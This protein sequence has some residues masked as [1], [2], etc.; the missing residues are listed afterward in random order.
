MRIVAAALA[1]LAVPPVTA[2][3]NLTVEGWTFTGLALLLLVAGTVL[4]F[5]RRVHMRD[6]QESTGAS[7]TLTLS[8][9]FLYTASLLVPWSGSYMPGAFLWG[10][11]VR[12]GPG[13]PDTLFLFADQARTNS[14]YLLWLALPL[15][16]A[17]A[18]LTVVGGFRLLGK[19]PQGA[20]HWG[21]L[22]LLLGGSAMIL[23]IL[24]FDLSYELAFGAGLV[25][26][27]LCLG[28]T[29]LIGL[30]GK[31]RPPRRAPDEE[32]AAPPAFQDPDP[33]DEPFVPE[34]EPVEVPDAPPTPPAPAPQPP[35]AGTGP[36]KPNAPARAAPTK[37]PT[38]GAKPPAQ[39]PPKKPA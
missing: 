21:R 35:K 14:E 5:V 39:G 38:P 3:P 37:P 1:L 18:F 9:G 16:I 26:G 32:P 8:A 22:A 33:N 36:P 15:W 11:R 28:A 23:W 12:P 24:G 6:L 34:A 10:F 27:L 17:A 29:I 19:E 31:E 4:F 2:N 25:V 7:V 30:A 13:A 20:L